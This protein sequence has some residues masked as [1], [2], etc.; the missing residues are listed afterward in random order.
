MTGE[1]EGIVNTFEVSPD[2][3]KIDEDAYLADIEEYGLFTYEEFAQLINVPEEMFDAFQA[4][5][6]KV[7][8]GKGH[9]TLEDIL[10]LIMQYGKW[11]GL[12]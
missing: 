9:I 2:T 7:S 4:K 10:A 1:I 8:I 12:E 6:L 11:L 5:Y 3:I